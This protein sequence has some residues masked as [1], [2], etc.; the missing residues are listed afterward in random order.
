MQRESASHAFAGLRVL[1]VEDIADIR[2]LL[3]FLL[4][5]EG[6]EVRAAASAREALETAAMWSFDVLLTDLGLPDMG[7][8]DLI[9]EIL[10]MKSGVK[11]LVVTGFGE[12]YAG[13]ARRAGANVVFTKPLDWS[14]LRAQL[15]DRREVIA[16]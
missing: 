8:D 16:A 4:S 1:L 14:L 10:G 12:P 7:G 5:S 15:L 6:A 9:K 3:V 11:V 13:R 2:Q